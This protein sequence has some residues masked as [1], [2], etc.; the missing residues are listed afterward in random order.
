MSYNIEPLLLSVENVVTDGLNKLLK[1]FMNDYQI[2][3]KTHE[4]VL[5]IAENQSI[6][7]CNNNDKHSF[8]YDD[9]KTIKQSIAEMTE[10]MVQTEVKKLGDSLEKKIE[11][12]NKSN[13]RMISALITRIE[14]L[15]IDIHTFKQISVVKV[16]SVE[17]ENIVLKIEEPVEEQ[18]EE[19][20]EEEAE[21]EEAEEEEAEEEEAEEEEAEEEEA[22][23]EEAENEKEQEEDEELMEIEI[24]DITYCTNDEENGFIYELND[25]EVGKKVGYI[26][27]GEPTFF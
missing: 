3:K 20:E 7:D 14:S 16:D 9:N 2:Y 13:T 19:A 25:G 27:D 10:E 22:E 8:A 4:S 17:K 21:E 12:M 5:K 18:E 6:N 11:E 26:K 24:D 1:D 15:K 23:E